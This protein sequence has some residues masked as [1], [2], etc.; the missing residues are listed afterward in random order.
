MYLSTGTGIN[1]AEKAPEDVPSFCTMEQPGISVRF[2]ESWSTASMLIVVDA[3]SLMM[4]GR[5]ACW[6]SRLQDRKAEKEDAHSLNE[7]PLK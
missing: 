5:K 7:P 3:T 2:T 1:T 6:R 4:E